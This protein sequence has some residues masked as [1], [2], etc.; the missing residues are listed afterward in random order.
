MLEQA[1]VDAKALRDAAIESAE[2]VVVERYSK[3]IKDTVETLLEEDDLGMDMGMDTGMDMDMGM[4]AGMDAAPAGPT[5][6]E[7]DADEEWSSKGIGKVVKSLNTQLPEAFHPEIDDDKI[8]E[9]DL[10][11]LDLEDKEDLTVMTR[12]E[13]PVALEEDIELDEDSLNELVQILEEDI[14][15][16]CMSQC[17]NE[18]DNMQCVA[19]CVIASIPIAG[20]KNP[21]PSP[22]PD[23]PAGQSRDQESHKCVPVSKKSGSGLNL[24]PGALADTGPAVSRPAWMQESTEL[25]EEEGSCEKCGEEPCTCDCGSDLEESL[26]EAIYEKVAEA[27]KFDYKQVPDGGFANGQMKPTNSIEDTLEVAEVA[28]AIEEHD[29]ENSELKKENKELK[30]KLSKIIDGKN[31]LMETV[32]KIEEKFNEVQLMNAKLHYQ[33]QALTDASLNERQKTNIVESIEKTD[34]IEQAKIVFETLQSS[35]GNLFS[36]N[37]KSLSEVVG[38]RNSSSIL[39][40]ASEK[41]NKK[42]SSDFAQRMKALAGL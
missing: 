22:A 2:R 40:K 10:D 41:S 1:I 13:A 24:K 21:L 25:T 26:E 16:K 38:K 17:K 37:P 42:E 27:L 35:V 4:D 28:A 33:N 11:N 19:D 20:D 3:Q 5:A 30:D 9:I 29:E 6:A 34:S 7:T 14:E 15:S 31:E 32:S 18:K 36:K 39:L 12:E 23:C 8:L